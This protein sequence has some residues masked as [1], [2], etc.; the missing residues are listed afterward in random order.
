MHKVSS[1][2]L[3]LPPLSTGMMFRFVSI[4]LNI[5]F[6]ELEE[7]SVES[8]LNTKN[9]HG[10]SKKDTRPKKAMPYAFEDGKD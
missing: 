4:E 8:A 1:Q 5:N 2:E 9:N 7:A 6:Q 10:D 3:C